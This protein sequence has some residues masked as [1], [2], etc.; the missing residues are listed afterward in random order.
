MAK[1][2]IRSAIN[3]M[4][5]AL[6]DVFKDYTLDARRTAY[7]KLTDTPA[8]KREMNNLLRTPSRNLNGIRSLQFAEWLRES[9]QEVSHLSN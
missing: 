8:G 3:D 2:S 9:E 7:K 5:G 4:A 1:N 6:K